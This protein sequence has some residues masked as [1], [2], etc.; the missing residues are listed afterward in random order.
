M[1]ATFTLVAIEIGKTEQSK[2]PVV[3]SYSNGFFSDR[4][5][6]LNC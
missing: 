1:I 6:V 3:A 2:P 4:N 5:N